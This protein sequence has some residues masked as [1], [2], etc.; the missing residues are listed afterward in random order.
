MGVMSQDVR[1]MAVLIAAL[2]L[3]LVGCTSAPDPPRPTVEC[4]LFSVDGVCVDSIRSLGSSADLVVLVERDQSSVSVLEVV[5]PTSEAP[6]WPEEASL[7]IDFTMQAPS[8][9]GSDNLC[10]YEEPPTSGL[11]LLFLE[12]GPRDLY[13]PLGG[14]AGVFSEV[15]LQ[16]GP[17]LAS[18]LREPCG[19]QS[20]EVSGAADHVRTEVASSPQEG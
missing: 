11:L 13:T 3:M 17:G 5:L 4:Q 6:T 14:P 19:A 1:Q 20:L 16:D 15:Q 7:Q 9:P 8:I 18:A 10:P 2:Q 12:E